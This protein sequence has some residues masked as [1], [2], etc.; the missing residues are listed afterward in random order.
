VGSSTVRTAGLL[1]AILIA[2]GSATDARL[3]PPAEP[4][5]VARAEPSHAIGLWTPRHVSLN[6][7]PSCSAAFH[8]RYFVVAPDGHRYPTWHPPLAVDPATGRECAFGHEHGRDPRRSQ[9]WATRQ[10]QR[11]FYFD[12]NA[13]QRM[14]PDEEAWA[15]LPFGYVNQQADA[16][17]AAQRQATMRHEDHVGHK[18]EW[19][20]DETDIATHRMSTAKDG[21]VWIGQLGDGVMTRD[22]GMRCF[23][24]AKAHQGTSTP[25]AFR[26]NLHEV[27]FFQDCRH[28][29]D[30]AR[31]A[32][33]HD[34]TSCPDSHRQNSRV[35]LSMLFPFGRGG[36]FTKFAPLCGTDRRGDPR[37]FVAAGHSQYS[38]HYPE[39]PGDREI[40]TRDCIEKGFLVAEPQF[41]DNMYEAWPASLELRTDDDRAV[42]A[43][44]NM[45]FD[46]NDAA[47]YY[48]PERLK[49]ERGYDRRRPELAGTDMGY[50]Q[51]LCDEALET[52]RARTGECDAST[53]YRTRQVAWDDPRAAF[54]GLNRGMYF[55][56]PVIRNQWGAPV[57]YSD[58]FG[59]GASRKPFP[60]AIRQEVTTRHLDY[61][62]LIAGRPIDPR[63][64]LRVH[65][66][67]RGT[68]HAPN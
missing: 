19:A 59:R 28:K 39:G 21:G 66:D 23:F 51:D 18:V 36:G 43:G 41:S 65:D 9:L 49:V 52:R 64:A 11:A 54:R 60:G 26:N 20:N 14:D 63:V 61:S 38:Q 44:V 6:G 67:G 8:D 47:R 34:L 17:F 68:V 32:D 22:T 24:L 7:V 15:G 50:A 45:L 53:A 57:W 33:A 40:A 16:W 29:S 48:Y 42:V 2:V 12:A 55:Q 27:M 5:W 1:T 25:D 10:V 13:N 4:D 58:P 3:E 62:Q 37:D 46:V 56:P 30:L 31:C 35:S